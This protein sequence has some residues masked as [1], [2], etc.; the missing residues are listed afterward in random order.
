MNNQNENFLIYEYNIEKGNSSGSHYLREMGGLWA[1]TELEDY[2]G[3][4]RYN[5]LEMKGF[6]YFSQF[7]YEGSDGNTMIIR[8]ISNNDKIAYSAFMILAISNMEIDR[9]NEYLE[10]L[11][12]GLLLQQRED[13]SLITYFNSNSNDGIDYYPGESLFALMVLYNETGETKYLEAVQKAFPYYANYWRN[14]KNA[15]FIPWHSRANYM[16]YK[17]TKND[18]VANFV[19]EM[20]DWMIDYHNPSKNCSEFHF[21]KGIVSA[22]Y[23][24][25]MNKAYELAKEKGD[26]NRIECYENFVKEGAEA[27]MKLQVSP[28]ENLSEQAIGGFRGSTYSN[29]LRVD[30]NQHAVIALME[31]KT[32]NLLE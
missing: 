13:G 4:S 7:F 10:K 21:S 19:F 22:V 24:E 11:G 31:A 8:M 1:V 26:K 2:T 25:G 23:M 32:A 17:E 12:N 16:L 29:T 27:I 15:A 30:R 6:E 28:G 5:Q 18:E 3:D 9:K 14:N 20:N